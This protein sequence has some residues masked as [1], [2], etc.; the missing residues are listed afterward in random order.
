MTLDANS[1]TDLPGDNTER[2]LAGDH[3]ADPRGGQ[4][5]SVESFSLDDRYTR[6]QGTIYLT[7]IQALVRMVRDRARL[8][9]RQ[10]LTTGSFIS[11]YEGSPLAGYDLEIAKRGKYLT[12][13][14]IVHRP[15]LNEE[16]AATSV[17]GS[18][19]AAQVGT[20][21]RGLDGV[22]GYWYGKAPGLDRATDA[23]RHANLIG[24]HASGGAVALVGDDPGAKSSTVPCASE[25]ALADLYMPI[26]YP[27]DSQDILDLGVHA[28]I[29]SRV[30]GL[31][32]SL[33]ISAHV[34][35][36]ASC[37]DVHP[38]RVLPVYGDLGMSPHV[39][40]GKLLGANLMELEQNQL[41]VRMPRATEYARINRLNR[42]TVRSSDDR[43]GIVA[44][45]KTYMDVRE[46]L[47]L[48]GIDDAELNKLGIR[49]LKMGMVYPFERQIMHEFIDGLDEVIVVEEKRDFLETMMR[50]ILFRHP[51]APNI[52]GKANEDGSTLFSRFGELDQ[53]SVTRGL[54]S[55][56]ARVHGVSAARDWLDRKAQQR[57]RIELPLAVRSPYFC[58]GCPHNTS[59]KVTDDTLVGAG[60]GCHAMVLLM[61]PQQVGDITGV[62]QMGGEG[63]QW[64]GM[65]PFLTEKHFVQNIGDGTFMHS[66]SLALRQSVASGERITYK[67]LFNGTVAMTGGQDPVGQMTLP[68]ICALLQAER[69][70]KI[71]VTSDDP[72]R[73]AASGLP[74]GVQV[75]H[76]ED[77][78]EVQRELAELPGVT[79]L[80]HDQYC[81]A[82]KRRKRKRDKYPTPNQRVVINERICEGC[83]DCGVKS[84]CLSVHPVETEFGRKTRID[85]SSCNLD[86]SCLKGDCPSFVTVTPGTQGKIRK[87]VPDIGADDVP[88]PVKAR[89]E[90][91]GF[92]IRVTG[93]GGTGVVTV[94]QILATATVLDGHVAR[95]VDMTGMAQ[96]GGAVISDV[97][98]S[99]GYVEQAAKVASG[100]CDV[101]L[102]CDGL[103]GVDP[104]NLKVASPERTTSIVSTTKIPTGQMVIDTAVGYPDQGS[105]H[106][107]I[108]QASLR[109]VYL[110]PGDLTLQ[111]FGDEQYA[112]MFMVGAAFQTGALPISSASI[113]R[114]IGL[115]GV[116]VEKNLQAFRRGRQSVA[117][118]AAVTA[119]I[120]ALHPMPAP[121]ALS[122][123][124]T[125]QAGKLDGASAEVL[126]QV[127]LRVDELVAYQDQAY[128]TRYADDVA[129]VFRAEKAWGSEDLTAAVAHNLHKLMA[130]KDEYEVARLSQDAEFAAQ[131][132]DEFGAD[133]KK[134][135]RLHPPTL[136]EMGLKNK[137]ALGEW[138]N[139][140][141]K[142]LATMKRLRGTKL[143]PFGMTAMRRMERTLIA[144]YRA[145][146]GL[147]IAAVE[148]G[149]V[150]DEQRE[151]V[152]ALAE[153]PDMVRGYEGVKTANV[154]KYRAAVQNQ[155]ETLGW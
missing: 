114:A 16:L 15:G 146:I 12:E 109:S 100:D 47:R 74:K 59:T 104:A 45:G 133:A 79:V 149:R 102:S 25:M 14:D 127:A 154:E 35:D 62:T 87:S 44:A 125:A 76:R 148:G 43:I 117:D 67:L 38:D 139:P 10:N 85:Q 147:M 118:P 78:I 29:M 98:V 128:A 5:A 7:G 32:T 124:A 2:D 93:I 40:S 115:N 120:D 86:F 80:V 84:N 112:N 48:I 144:E 97:K 82:E 33:K 132:A 11:G 99:A 58:S 111:L 72:K 101:Y 134:A 27:A 81:A 106:A 136:R 30:S 142:T 126:R 46:S 18:Q 89:R 151:Q 83:G 108:D 64:V 131:V 71:V 135:I 24:T 57:T 13:Y 107:A 138:V 90:S 53:D 36:G 50:D 54:A 60:I 137:L 9:R 26:L 69:V 121:V 123:F 96:K 68:Q 8:D 129:R 6:E 95:T 23:L 28:A 21:A 66:G 17:M 77:M 3:D 37:A 116:A 110:D 113:E 41:T 56:L 105:I 119:A 150:T 143:D 155:L 20:L 49:I 19:V 152:I 88:Q 55:R 4:S 73:T 42:I 153:L 94:S 61:D 92:A 34:A 39:P 31:W 75:R 140:G 52:V 70:T 22:V 63:A 141:M 91:D 1:P 122:A 51:G 145:L 130:Y 65:A 103:V